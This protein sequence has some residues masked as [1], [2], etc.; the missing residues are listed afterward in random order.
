M[1]EILPTRRKTLSNQSINQT[2]NQSVITP[3]TC[4]YLK[5]NLQPLTFH[6]VQNALHEFTR[7]TPKN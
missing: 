6:K 1:A 2:I 4:F 3:Q 5:K 7:V